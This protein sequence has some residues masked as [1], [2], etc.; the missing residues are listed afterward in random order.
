MDSLMLTKSKVSIYTDVV[1][2]G[3]SKF[4]IGGGIIESIPAEWCVVFSRQTVCEHHYG[5]PYERWY[6]FVTKPTRKQIRKA[7][8][9]FKVGYDMYEH[10][11]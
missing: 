9:H 5:I 8:K 2:V 1:F 11:N 7:R 6:T 3:A 10:Y 4:S